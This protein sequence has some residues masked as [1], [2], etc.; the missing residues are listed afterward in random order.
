M[1]HFRLKLSA[2]KELVLEQLV[3]PCVEP[4]TSRHNTPIL[5][6]KRSHGN[7]DFYWIW[8][9]LMNTWKMGNTQAGLPHPSAIPPKYHVMILDIKDCFFQIPLTPQNRCRF[10]YT[11]WET[12]KPAKR[13][14]WSVLP[15]AW[16][17]TYLSVICGWSHTGVPRDVLVTHYMGYILCL[18]ILAAWSWKGV[19]SIVG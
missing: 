6:I 1:S 19:L 15:R 13:Y 4:S 8:E 14:Q 12:N 2:L 16:K 9:P 17:I 5:V 18:H 7:I 3:L 10:A 11:V